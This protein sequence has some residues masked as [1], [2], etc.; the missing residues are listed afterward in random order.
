MGWQRY[1]RYRD[2]RWL[3]CGAH[4]DGRFISRRIAAVTYSDLRPRFVAEDLAVHF[5]CCV[6]IA[7]VYRQNHIPWHHACLIRRSARN[8]TREGY[9]IMSGHGIVVRGSTYRP[10]GNGGCGLRFLICH[11]LAGLLTY[12][13]A[14]NKKQAH[15]PFCKTLP[16]HSAAPFPCQIYTDLGCGSPVSLRCRQLYRAPFSKSVRRGAPPAARPGFRFRVAGIPTEVY[17]RQHFLYFSPLPHGQ[18]AFR[19]IFFSR[20]SPLTFEG[21]RPFKKSLAATSI[22]V[23]GSHL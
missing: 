6:Q 5:L 7:T 15:Q 1:G 10:F 4:N 20:L 21:R 14:A 18:G 11:R 2:R 22:L 23:L 19:P 16:M 17:F 13:G 9:S 3:L 12:K 8:H